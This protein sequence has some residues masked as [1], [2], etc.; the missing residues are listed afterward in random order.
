MGKTILVVIALLLAFACGALALEILKRSADEKITDNKLADMEAKLRAEISASKPAPPKEDASLEEI[1]SRLAELD[2]RARALAEENK[3]LKE[4]IEE[5]RKKAVREA[6]NPKAKP[7][8]RRTLPDFSKM[9][10]EEQQAWRKLLRDEFTKFGR[11]NAGGFRDG[12]LRRM[13]MQIDKNEEKLG[14]TPA[15]K[16][17]LDAILSEQV[18]KG[19]EIVMKLFQE[20]NMQ[21]ASSHDQRQHQDGSQAIKLAVTLLPTLG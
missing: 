9:T 18:N 1:R 10:S 6:A 8:P 2:S 4:E 13:R 7:E 20:G 3:S 17:D 21:Q 19:F 12:I 5:L 16:A 14:L 11:E 15:Q